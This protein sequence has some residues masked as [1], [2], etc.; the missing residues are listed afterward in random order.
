MCL[1]GLIKHFWHSIL[2]SLLLLNSFS[3]GQC[4]DPVDC[5]PPGS[6]VPGV[7]Q[8]RMLQWVAMPSS[9]GSS[10]LRDQT[11][12]SYICYIG[13]LHLLYWQTISLP[14]APPGKP[15]YLVLKMIKRVINYSS[16]IFFHLLKIYHVHEVPFIIWSLIFGPWKQNTRVCVSL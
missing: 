12:I 10:W 8:A 11:H 3:R 2:F 7:L 9:R 14:L 13:L 5:S 6:S 4:C 15:F 1:F 16:Q